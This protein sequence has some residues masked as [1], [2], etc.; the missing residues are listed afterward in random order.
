M[1]AAPTPILF[2]FLKVFSTI[3][4]AGLPTTWG[5]VVF[6]YQINAV[7]QRG[8]MSSLIIKTMLYSNVGKC[9]LLLSN[10]AVQPISRSTA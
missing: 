2:S 9:R 3:T 5:D 4:L 6:Y 1:F 7:Q 10:H 8:K